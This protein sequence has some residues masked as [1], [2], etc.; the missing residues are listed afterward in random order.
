MARVLDSVTLPIKKNGTKTNQNYVNNPKSTA[1]QFSTSTAY[2][3]GQYVYYDKKLYRF[4]TAHAAGA[5]NA[6][7]VTEVTVTSELAS[8]KAETNDLKQDLE[9]LDVYTLGLYPQMSVA[10]T[11]V[12]SFT[13]GADDIPVKSLMVDITPV[14]SG[15][16]D[17]S[18]SNVRPISGWTGANVAV[19]GKNLF[20]KATAQKGKW[21]STSTGQIESA[22]ALFYV[23][24][25]IP[26]LANS[27][28]YIPNTG[29]SRRWFYD[30]N[31]APKTY[32]STSSAQVFTPTENGY[33]RV[34][35]NTD[36]NIGVVLDNVQIE[37][38]SS[39][40]TYEPFGTVYPITFPT[41]AGTVYGGTLDVT[42]GVLTVTNGYVDLGTLTWAYESGDHSRF[43]ANLSNIAVSASATTVVPLVCSIYVADSTQNIYLHHADNTIGSHDVNH[44]VWVYNSA[45]SDAA[46]FK[47]AMSGVQLAYPLATPQTYQLDPVAVATILGQNNIFCD[48]GDIAELTYRADLKAYIDAHVGS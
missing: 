5:W 18:P 31:K 32:L 26:V 39:A 19:T 44:Q 46:T 34:T 14:Q 48:T 20:D 29:S 40:T 21:L 41:S 6:S 22:D 27:P 42:N 4:T 11:A 30:A 17:P 1:G 2:A 3:V 12:A 36:L 33:I 8:L 38:G 28:I 16:G 13:D 10:D 35:V 37:Y 7:H 43:Y 23:S 15:S 25:Y 45:Y 24:G 9:G 47:T